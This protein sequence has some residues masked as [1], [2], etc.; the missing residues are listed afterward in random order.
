[1]PRYDTSTRPIPLDGQ[2]VQTSQGEECE[3][4]VVNFVK[5]FP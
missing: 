1:M 2:Y 5:V 4:V 3:R